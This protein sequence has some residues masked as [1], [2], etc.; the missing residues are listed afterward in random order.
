MFTGV[1]PAVELSVQVVHPTLGAHIILKR[2]KFEARILTHFAVNV[3]IAS[4]IFSP[5]LRRLDHRGRSGGGIMRAMIEKVLLHSCC[6]PCSAAIIEWMRAHNIEPVVYFF[7]PNI[8]PQEEYDKRKAEL[9]RYCRE[10]GITVIDGDRDHEA[11]LTA[12]R[13]L[14]N[15]PERGRRCQACFNLRLSAAAAKARELGIARFTT[16]LASSR[17]KSLEQVSRAGRLAQEAHPGVLFWDRNWRK[18][19]LQD[20]RAELL[21]IHNFYNQLWCG[22]EFS[23][24]A[25]LRRQQAREQAAETCAA[26]S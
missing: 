25:M 6:A 9:V 8:A 19:G 13:G 21:K 12:V 22:C 18:E 14:E 1:F 11:W 10:L 7:N 3:N 5:V 24:R 2:K 16:S 15:E 23:Q 20:R 4:A 17:W 26:A